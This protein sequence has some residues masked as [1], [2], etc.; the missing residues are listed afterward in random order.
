MAHS[1]AEVATIQ[2]V[3]PSAAHII[4]GG[5]IFSGLGIAVYPGQ[6]SSPVEIEQVL[7]LL[8]AGLCFITVIAIFISSAFG[9]PKLHWTESEVI[10]TSFLGRTTRLRLADFGPATPY[11]TYHE[12]FKNGTFLLFRPIS[13]GKVIHLALSGYGYTEAQLAE[14]ADRINKTRGM[15]PGATDEQALIEARN[16]RGLSMLLILLVIPLVFLL[17]ILFLKKF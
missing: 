13:G 17:Y 6:L 14:L 1:T 3:R 5:L 7:R 4:L 9:C 15:P 10:F 11:I 2:E 8:V 16:S 12:E